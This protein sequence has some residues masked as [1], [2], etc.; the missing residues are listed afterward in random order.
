MSSFLIDYPF[1]DPA[2][3]RR[4]AD[5]RATA[6]VVLRVA[7]LSD[8]DVVFQ[9]RKVERSGLWDAV[10]GRVM[11][12]LHK[13]Q[14]LDAVERHYPARHYVMVDDKLRILAAMKAK[15]GDT[16]DDG[17]RP[18]GTLR[19][20]YRQPHE[21]S[22]RRYHHRADRRLTPERITSIIAERIPG[23]NTERIADPGKD[24]AGRLSG[25]K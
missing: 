13:E 5:G 2:V 16:A 15:L 1:A 11:I 22:G 7:I 12:Y 9:P 20:R 8:G 6:R 25:I 19:A 10:E 24:P 23:T 14:M 21:L 18:P 3:S 17:V 4:A